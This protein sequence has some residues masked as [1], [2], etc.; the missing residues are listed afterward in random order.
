MKVNIRF[1]SIIVLFLSIIT[2]SCN[3]KSG[4]DKETELS[5]FFISDS[6]SQIDNFSRIKSVIDRAGDETNIILV[7]SGDIFSGNPLVDF[8]SE[9]GYP[10]IDLMNRVGFDLATLG[11]HEF[12]YGQE[13]LQER[14]EQAEFEFICANMI[15]SSP[16]LEQTPAHVV[17]NEGDLKLIFTGVIET[18]GK[19][20]A[21]IPSTHPGKLDNLVFKDAADILGDYSGLKEESGSDLH[22]LLSHLGHNDDRGAS[23]DYSVAHDF[24]YFD[25]I[26][27]GHSHSIQDTT[28]NGVHIYQAGSYLDYLGKISLVIKDKKIMSEDFELI[29][30]DAYPESDEELNA[31]IDL[32][33]NNP[34]FS[35][36]IGTNDID[37]T[38]NRTAGCFYTDALM[39]YLGTDMAFQNPGGI[40]ADLDTGDISLME[41]YR[42]DPFGNGL[43]RYEMT[44]SEIKNFLKGTGAGFYYAGVKIENDPSGGIIIKGPEGNVYHDDRKLSIAINDYIPMVHEEYFPDPAEIYDIT[45]AEAMIHYLRELDVPLSYDSCNR[46]FRYRD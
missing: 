37:L 28:I 18:K 45:T 9:K 13:V 20:G 6:H 42:I 44:V 3:N 39:S 27:G 4:Q 36:V 14:M 30:L 16:L 32:Y 7:S 19:P 24:P 26:I 35:E 22:I 10:V 29:D 25:A 31:I 21:V 41:I 1:I 5:I 33:N 15:S 11:N 17:L 46:Y 43:C 34:A 23:S 2:T 12:D 40:R 38:R 8:Y